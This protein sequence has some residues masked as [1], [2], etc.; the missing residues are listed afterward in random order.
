M[1]ASSSDGP[2]A[3]PRWPDPTWIAHAIGRRVSVRLDA[4]RPGPSGGPGYRDVVGFLESANNDSW[5]IRTRHGAT[6]SVDPTLVVAAKVVPDAPARLR[7]ASD[8]DIASLELIAAEGWRPL[9]RDTL[10]GW[11]LRA[12][13]GFTGRANSVLPIGDPGVP[14]DAAIDTVCSWY[15]ARGLPPMFQLPLPLRDDLNN[16]LT[17]RGWDH[18]H[19]THV[20]VS[21]LDPLRMAIEKSRRDPDEVDL[22]TANQ[23]DDDWRDAFRYGD[24]RIP[25]AVTPILT[26]SDHPVFAT[27]RGRDGTLRAIGRGAVTGQWLG[28]TAVEVGEPH[29]RQGLGQQVIGAL[30]DYATARGARHVYL[31]VG[32]DNAPALALYT[33]LGF[34][35]HHDYVYRLLVSG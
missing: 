31:Q 9:E 8:I 34:E 4:E 28:V 12:A 10:G 17:A 11:S 14:L 27:A 25:A 35:R 13:A 19:H 32:Q 22:E 23:P 15:A 24:I 2:A 21:D 26:A 1:C 30:A 7:T 16:A 20:M 3:D 5:S 6:K 29:R 18:Y 33:R